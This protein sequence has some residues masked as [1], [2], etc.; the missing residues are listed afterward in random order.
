MDFYLSYS[1]KCQG[2]SGGP[3]YQFTG[4]QTQFLYTLSNH[5][6]QAFD[7]TVR[8]TGNVTKIKPFFRP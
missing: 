6:N 3:L 2:E 8:C 4:K 5:L 1:S 7:I